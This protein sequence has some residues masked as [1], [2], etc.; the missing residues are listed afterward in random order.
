[1]AFF[2]KFL[3]KI[4]DDDSSKGFKGSPTET[5]YFGTVKADP[6]FNAQNDAAKLKKAI[7]TKGVDEATIVEV[8]AKRSN[9]QRQQIKAAYQQDTG[10]PL[11]D[12][13]RKAL[14][15]DFEE[16]VLALLMTP[17]EYDAFEIKRA[18]K[19]LGTKEAVLSE[20]LGTRSNK[21]I[22]A[23]KTS[24]KEVY[25]ELLEEDLK[26]EISGHLETVLLALCKAT[27]S[28]DYNID[29]GLAKSDAKALF[30]AGEN[31]VGT[32]CSV[33]IDV[34]TSRSEAQL[35]KIFKYYGQYSK[36][37]LAKALESELHGNLEDCLMT[38]VKSA[39]NKPALFA[40]KLHLAM[41]GIG[42]N[43]DTLTRIIVSRSE[44]DLLK[45]IQEYKRMY[46]KTLQE[47][48]LKE[49]SGDYEKILL[50]LCGTQSRKMA[51]LQ[52]LFQQSNE[53]KGFKAA[54]AVETGYLGTVKA[55]P[56]FNAQNDAAKLKKAIETKGVDEATI[57]EV[58]AKR[59]NAQRQ[60]IKAAYQQ[61]AGKPLADDLKKAL[62]SDFEEVVLA[63]LMTPPEYDAF[64]MKRA[65][66]NLG[67]NENVLSEILGTRS[68]KEIAALKNTFK[69]VY[70]EM[71]E[72]DIKC[73]VKGDL[74]TT[75]VA[76]CKATR[77]EDRNIDDGMA[78][79]DAKALFEA[80]ENR[81]GTVCSVL[82]DILTNRSEAQLCKILQ[83]YGQL[84]KDG[85]AKDLEGEL[86]GSFEDCLMTLVKS[87]WNKPAYFAEKLHLAMKGLGTNT[88]TLT[89][90]IVSRS[91]ID[92]LKIIQEYKRMYGKTLQEAILKE[93][94]GDYE[95]IL[96]A[97]CG[98]Q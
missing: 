1:M 82:I 63:L 30:E 47:A 72:E 35:C 42:T 37:G 83:Y 75:L 81:I 88:D 31:R 51:F 96:L 8:L 86:H 6:N 20:I 90:I 64:E 39:W 44:I 36:Q 78:K 65:M 26:S 45:I 57:V 46:G 58:L 48:I 29:D 73:E 43:T 76:L 5:A 79:S 2:Q 61:S 67:T 87:A 41:K 17:P 97:L 23:M 56:N 60:Q 93:T 19:G 38:L 59:S 12:A 80:G 7:E 71:L 13:L 32:V 52:K 27:R 50:A 53:E 68:N 40:E 62:K 66:K 22:T 21:E 16:V 98:T 89:R 70:G 49:T 9:A 33:L 92:L 11:V 74:E 91:E 28:E 84:S 24:F 25:G 94:S 4:S 3:Q 54:P 10:K 55:D 15:S 34:L 18:M 14:K 85:L 95:K 69:E 77:S